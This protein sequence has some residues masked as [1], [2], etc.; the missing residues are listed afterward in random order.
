MVWKCV[1][2]DFNVDKVT[3][4]IKEH[5]PSIED[6][7]ISTPREFFLETQILIHV[8]ALTPMNTRTHTLPL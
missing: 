1:S 8:R 5:I 4:D 7:K 6:E 2:F 3:Q